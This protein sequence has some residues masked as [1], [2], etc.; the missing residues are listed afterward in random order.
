MN[1]FLTR[2]PDFEDKKLNEIVGLLTMHGGEMI[3]RIM[4]NPLNFNTDNF[5]WDE[6]FSELRRYRNDYNIAED[7]TIVLLTGLRNNQNW[8]STPNPEG[9]KEIFIHTKDWE[10]YI[11]CDSKY[12]IAFQVIENI[13]QML[14][15]NVNEDILGLYHE[16]PI[17]CFNDMVS[18]KP[19]ISFKLRT[20]DIC[21][22][23]LDRMIEKEVP[24]NIIKQSLKIMNTLREYMLFSSS[25]IE[26][27]DFDNFLPYPIA[28]TKRKMAVIIEPFRKFLLLI[29]HFDSLI[30]TTVLYL[31]SVYFTA[32]EKEKFLTDNELR[33]NPS[34]GK[35]VN[36]L[37]NLGAINANFKINDFQKQI[38]DEIVNIA[39]DEKIVK[40]RNEERG[41]GYIN[42]YDENYRKNFNK[43]LEQIK[44]IE[45]LLVPLFYRKK[46]YKIRGEEKISEVSFKITLNDL[47]G[48]NSNFLEENFEINFTDVKEVPINGKIYIYDEDSNRF[49]NTN[50][51]F[52]LQECPKCRHSRFLIY[53]TE[54]PQNKI[55]YIDTLIGHMVEI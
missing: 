13:L 17:G 24:I 39:K 25:Y 18:F 41:H 15:F 26:K 2:T 11:Y 8:F 28:I 47:M 20:A 30:R 51:F 10:N 7:D 38:F 34:L 48:S 27:Q 53:N 52:L 23:C 54:R 36:A 9:S 6:I 46:L 43:L 1:I 3:F 29:D 45:N 31:L 42:L 50:P 21:K 12:P 44:K 22:D 16:P 32:D 33:Q 5:E 35:W 14:A 4:N 40:I 19:H 37:G 49:Y 55:Q